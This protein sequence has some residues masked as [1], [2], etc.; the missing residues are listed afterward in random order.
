[1]LNEGFFLYVLRIIT[2]PH[3]IFFYILIMNSSSKK[4]CVMMNIEFNL[5]RDEKKPFPVVLAHSG[6]VLTLKRYFMIFQ[7]PNLLKST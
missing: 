7:G 4:K 1:M 3:N 5:A 6:N 2:L